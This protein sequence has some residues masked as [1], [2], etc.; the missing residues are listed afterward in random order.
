MM[1]PKLDTDIAPEWSM[2]ASSFFVKQRITARKSGIN[3]GS[4]VGVKK[5][6]KGGGRGRVSGQLFFV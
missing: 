6:G 1:W 3:V 5:G 2:S 4:G